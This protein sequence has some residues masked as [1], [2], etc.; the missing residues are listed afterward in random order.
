MSKEINFLAGLCFSLRQILM[1]VQRGSLSVT[2]IHAVLTSQGG[3]T[4]S[5]E[6]VSMTME[7]TLLPGSPVLVSNHQQSLFFIIYLFS[8]PS[9]LVHGV[10]K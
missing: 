4:V 3:T 6:A 7:A 8:P 1:S 9:L 10:P 5:A 2:T